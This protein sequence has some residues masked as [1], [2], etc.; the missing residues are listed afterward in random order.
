MPNIMDNASRWQ[1]MIVTDVELLAT[2]WRAYQ[3][4]RHGIQVSLSFWEFCELRDMHKSARIQ[5]N[6]AGMM[7]KIK[8][9]GGVVEGANDWKG[10]S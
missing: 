4:L 5:W 3:S 10:D 7:R 9:E 2:N 1:D 8:A 6:Y